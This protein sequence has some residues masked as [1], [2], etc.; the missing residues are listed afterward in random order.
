PSPAVHAPRRGA[1]AGA[2]RPGASGACVRPAAP[3]AGIPGA[4]LP[5][6]RARPGPGEGPGR[7]G[8]AVRPAAPPGAVPGPDPRLAEAAGGGESPRPPALQP[9]RP[10]R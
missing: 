6:T 2:G 8:P 1:T 7:V 9:G 3:E 4:R 10:P 5:A